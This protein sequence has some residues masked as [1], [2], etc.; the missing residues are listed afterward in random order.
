M[1]L[2]TYKILH[3][4]S[5]MILFFAF[6]GVILGAWNAGGRQFANRKLFTVLHGVGLF[7][8]L[9]SGFG[10]M[11]KLGIVK[12]WP[13]WVVVKLV[14]WLILGG[15]LSAALRKPSFNKYLWIILLALGTYAAYLGHLKPI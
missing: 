5:I 2:S 1:D 4:V 12:G 6:G 3:Y 14:L 10:Q 13:T 11:A 15:L 8:L 9:L 7:F